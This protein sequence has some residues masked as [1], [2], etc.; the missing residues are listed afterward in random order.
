MEYDKYNIIYKSNYCLKKTILLYKT[1]TPYQLQ[2]PN[3]SRCFFQNFC[4]FFLFNS[5]CCY[6]QKPHLF[7]LYFEIII[8]IIAE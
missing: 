6:I 1:L 7:F 8:L 3:E 2:N 4:Y 5:L